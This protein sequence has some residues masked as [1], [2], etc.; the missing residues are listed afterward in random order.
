MRPKRILIVKF[1]ELLVYCGV[2]LMASLTAVALA[3]RFEFGIGLLLIAFLLDTLFMQEMPGLDL[4]VWVYPQDVINCLLLSA[5]AVRLL[6]CQARLRRARWIG[7]L[8]LGMFLLAFLR[9]LPLYSLKAVGN[10]TRSFLPFLAALVY[11]SSFKYD[12][13]RQARLIAIWLAG[14]VVFGILTFFR[15]I[16]GTLGWGIANQWQAVV[17]EGSMRVIP[18][19]HALYLGTAFFFSLY[20]Y[21]TNSG[22]IWQRRLFLV[23]GPMLVL[24]QHRTVWI[25][26]I[27]GMLWLCARDARFRTRGRLAG[28]WGAPHAAAIRF[29]GR[30]HTALLAAFR[31]RHGYLCLAD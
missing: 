7:I 15:W 14:S 30:E 5:A 28:G 21:Y 26:V 8:L 12:R 25:A 2:A 24:L 19:P 6:L 9:G 13:R 1:V 3:R 17:G 10:E 20:Q 22:S 31:F 16:A 23:L 4:G 18:S 11:F 27:L 29:V